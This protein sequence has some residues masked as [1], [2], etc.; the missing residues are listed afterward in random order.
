MESLTGGLALIA[1]LAQAAV[2]AA[3]DRPPVLSVEAS[4]EDPGQ[5]GLVVLVIRSR[6][7]ARVPARRGG[8]PRRLARAGA[9]RVGVSRARG[10]RSGGLSGSMGAAL[11][12][13]RLRREPLL[14][15]SRP[16]ASFRAASPSSPCASIRSSS[17]RPRRK[18]AAFGP[19]GRRSPPS[20]ASPTPGGAGPGPFATRSRRRCGTTSESGVSSTGSRA[21]VTTA[22]TSP[23]RPGR[24]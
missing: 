18:R 8:R 21:R 17:S 14:R 22:S 4:R 1:V 11:R 12:G 2:P 10:G 9:R 15:T 3:P 6:A 19:I 20:G 7:A 16:F 24:R 13:R 5:G 23:P